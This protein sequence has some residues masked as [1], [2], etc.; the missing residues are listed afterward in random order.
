ML[1]KSGRK[2][3]E[4]GGS[5]PDPFNFTEWMNMPLECSYIY[6]LTVVASVYVDKE[7]VRQECYVGLTSVYF[8]SEES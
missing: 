2:R 5:L 8:K 7:D 6:I 3:E 1:L 4:G